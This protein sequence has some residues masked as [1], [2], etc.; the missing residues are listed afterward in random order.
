MC[1]GE[2]SITEIA[3]KLAKK[4]VT[5]KN[6][7]GINKKSYDMTET[8]D[9]TALEAYRGT[10]SKKGNSNRTS[11]YQRQ[12]FFKDEHMVTLFHLL[13]KGNKLKLPMARRQ[14]KWDDERSQLLSFP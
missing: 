7:W 8:S 3:E 4:F 9:T 13:K 6:R 14:A 1:A 5:P 12:Y 2:T 10:R 11:E